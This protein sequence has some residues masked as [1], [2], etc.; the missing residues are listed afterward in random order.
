MTN[1]GTRTASKGTGAIL[2]FLV[3]LRCHSIKQPPPVPGKTEMPGSSPQA[4]YDTAAASP[5]A[6]GEQSKDQE[7]GDN[8]F[9]S[10][11]QQPAPAAGAAGGRPLASDSR[12]W[13]EVRGNLTLRLDPREKGGISALC[14]IQDSVVTMRASRRSVQ[15]PDEDPAVIVRVRISQL[16]VRLLPEYTSM[17]CA[18]SSERP[19]E[20]IYCF[21]ENQEKRNKWVAML[22]RM[23]VTIYGSSGEVALTA[24]T[25]V[26]SIRQG[27]PE[28]RPTSLEVAPAQ[29]RSGEGEGEGEERPTF[30]GEE[31][32]AKS[33]PPSRGAPTLPDGAPEPEEGPTAPDGAPEQAGTRSANVTSDSS[34]KPLASHAAPTLPRRN[35][36]SRGIHRGLQ[37]YMTIV[38]RR[39]QTPSRRSPL[40]SPRTNTRTLSPRSTLTAGG[41]NSG[42]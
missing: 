23:G 38:N 12:P 24:T 35:A 15:S 37:A 9:C 10:D 3:L 31:R 14:T 8:I 18:A 34:E 17:F 42:T 25:V 11:E 19:D 32:P 26:P 16:T 30:G 36:A 27:H 5:Q 2:R 39:N 29:A 33:A 40:S 1:P 21:A 4:R 20:N 22:R 28:Q 6:E 13:P 41:E 7:T